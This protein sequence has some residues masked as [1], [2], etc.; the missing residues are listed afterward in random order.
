MRAAPVNDDAQMRQVLAFW[1]GEPAD[2]AT[3]ATRQAPLWWG[4]SA[5][6][7]A[8]IRERFAERRTQAISGALDAWLALPH[9][10]LALIILIDQFSRNLYRNDAAAFAHDAQALAWCRQGLAQRSDQALTPIE[11][12]FFYLPLE[13]SESLADQ[14]RSVTLFEQLA[15]DAGDADRGA[16]ANFADFARQHQAIIQRFGRFPHRNAVLGRSSTAEETAFLREPG[17]SF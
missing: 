1:F 13:H 11:R 17:S 3:I 4:K 16:F 12:V 5:Q 6:T 7:D 9:G 14:Q 8:L 10:R 15:T 2:A